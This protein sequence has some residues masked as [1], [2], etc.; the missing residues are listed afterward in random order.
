[1]RDNKNKDFEIHAVAIHVKIIF[2]VKP[3][4]N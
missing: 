2:F 4:K 3:P 1:M